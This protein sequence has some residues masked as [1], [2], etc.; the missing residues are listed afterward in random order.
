[1]PLDILAGMGKTRALVSLLSQEFLLDVMLMKSVVTPLQSLYRSKLRGK[2]EWEHPAVFEVH[3]VSLH[4]GKF[5]RFVNTWCPFVVP[6]LNELSM[7][8]E[9]SLPQ[10]S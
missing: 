5:I 8:Y 4:M 9:D 7:V 6:H 10:I 1:M 2:A 3:L